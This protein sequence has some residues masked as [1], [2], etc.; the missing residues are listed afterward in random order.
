ML[1]K[2]VEG[3]VLKKYS[4][5]YYIEDQQKCIY[6][7]RLRGKIK[8]LVA[9]GDRVI[10]SVLEPGSGVLEEVLPRKS[11]LYRPRIANV[12]LVLIVL[13]CN[14][15]APSTMLLDRLLV[16]ANFHGL[17]TCLI[18]NKCDLEPHESAKTIMDYYPRAGFT[19]LCTSVPNHAGIDRLEEEIRGEIAVFAGPSGAGKSSL[20]SRLLGG[21][22]VETQEVSRRIGRGK[23]TT[24]HVELFRLQSD[25]WIADT[26]GFS[27]L[28]LPP[29]PSRD[30]KNY[31]PDFEEYAEGCRFADCMHAGEADCSVKM[32]VQ[33]Q[34][35]P[36]FRYQNYTALLSE[37][38]EKE[39][40]YR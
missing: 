20:L 23:H 21:L 25:G 8:E 40:C 15:P 3:L 37:L 11:E 24:R 4:G 39:R 29:M 9:T 7:C 33:N 22:E 5:F 36:E 16:L 35:I 38:A 32:A 12:T 13:A 19:T 14:Q 10:I 26:P 2:K 27:M 6:Q 30:L 31:F 1:N 18:M 34:N 28:D 17:R